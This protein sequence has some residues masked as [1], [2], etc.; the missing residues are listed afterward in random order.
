MSDFKKNQ[1]HQKQI[2]RAIK[3]YLILALFINLIY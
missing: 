3:I 2:D 1:I